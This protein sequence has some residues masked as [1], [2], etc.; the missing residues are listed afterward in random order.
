[1]GTPCTVHRWWVWC[2]AACDNELA[3]RW[4]AP[5]KGRGARHQCR[6]QGILRR[7]CCIPPQTSLQGVAVRGTPTPGI[8]YNELS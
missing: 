4:A 2:P 6:V 3:S 1:M 8:V 5:G 7:S